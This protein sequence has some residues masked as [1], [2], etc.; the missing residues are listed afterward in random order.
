M[1]REFPP[2]TAYTGGIGTTFAAIASALA[3]QGH[4]VH[5]VTITTERPRREVA[6]GVQVS[7]LKRP[8]P[9]RL[10]FLEDVTWT[11]PVARRLRALG[12]FDAVLAAEWGGDAA[13]YAHRKPSGPLATNLTTS[14]EQ[15]VA[16]SHGWQRGRRMRTRHAMQSRLER[17]QAER[18]DLLIASSRA[19]L[20]WTRRLWDVD[21]IPNVVLPNGVDVARTR[22]LSLGT[23]P[24]GFPVGRPV[25]AFSGRLEGRKGVQVLVPAMR[26]V[27]R[28]HPDAQLVLMGRDGDWEGGRMSDHLR[29]LA[30]S[31]GD[32]MHVLGLQPPAR[33]FAALRAAD[34]VALPSIWENFALAAVETLALGRPLIATRGSGYD[35]FVTSGANGL[36]VAPDDETALADA[37]VRLLDDDG[38]RARLAAAAAVTG[39][40]LDSAVVATRFADALG[41]LAGR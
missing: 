10:W 6:D 39:E 19:I 40:T 37:I 35:D 41:T 1:T 31:H 4:E 12:R 2:I 5:V 34:V 32:R 17:A 23:L 18:S 33:L 27:W 8:N 38:L 14:I 15:A 13:L 28:R 30:G 22:E 16:I 3:R 29:V 25:V 36:L 20:D 9:E 7:V 24:E 21:D 26:E 11:V